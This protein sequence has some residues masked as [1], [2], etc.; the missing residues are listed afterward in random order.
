MLKKAADLAALQIY[1][2]DES[3]LED[4]AE[5]NE[6][7]EDA[8]LLGR[9]QG[10]A[11]LDIRFVNEEQHQNDQQTH[12]H[13]GPAVGQPGQGQG[14]LQAPEQALDEYIEGIRTQIGQQEQAH[15]KVS[16]H[17]SDQKDPD[18]H[19]PFPRASFHCRPSLSNSA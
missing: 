18:P 5:Y 3:V 4:A 8:A 14:F 13:M 10:S 2:A 6:L 7:V 15:A 16:D 19:G 17:K 12:A 1:N 11:D 9:A